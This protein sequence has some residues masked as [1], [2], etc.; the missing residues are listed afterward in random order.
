M[1][2]LAIIGVL[3]AISV[4]S[5]VRARARGQQSACITNLRQIDWAKQ[6]WA[7]ETRASGTVVPAKAQI[8]PYLGRSG[9]IEAI[10]CP[11]GGDKPFD[12]CYSI[13]SLGEVPTCKIEPKYHSLE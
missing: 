4:P 12:D 13:N 8:A 5:F 9:N 10:V 6:Q 2:V 3:A 1:V 7:L 11:A